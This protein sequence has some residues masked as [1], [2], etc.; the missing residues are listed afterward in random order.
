MN[1]SS[2]G[3]YIRE[4]EGDEPKLVERTKPGDGK[5]RDAKGKPTKV[6]NPPE[7]VDPKPSESAT[8]K[9]AEKPVVKKEEK[10]DG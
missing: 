3:R 5:L 9:P 8:V 4:K 2:G 6:D 1:I 10:A 7:T